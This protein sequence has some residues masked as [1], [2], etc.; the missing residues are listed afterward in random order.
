MLWAPTAGSPP[1]LIQDPGSKQGSQQPQVSKG[2]IGR[3]VDK[4]AFK[5]AT[6]LPHTLRAVVTF[7]I[8]EVTTLNCCVCGGLASHWLTAPGHWHFLATNGI[9]GSGETDGF[10]QKCPQRPL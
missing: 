10:M 3:L 8:K 6:M 1:S 9:Q 5:N 7:C 4:E 2:E